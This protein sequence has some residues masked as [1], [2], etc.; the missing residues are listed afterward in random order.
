MYKHSTSILCKPKDRVRVLGVEVLLLEGLEL[1]HGHGGESD[2]GSDDERD[3]LDLV[4]LQISADA[5]DVFVL[6]VQLGDGGVEAHG[7]S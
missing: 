7:F 6:L 3:G 1:D 4:F 2:S 5:G